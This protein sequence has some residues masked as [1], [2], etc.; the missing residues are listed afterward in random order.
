MIGWEAVQSGVDGSWRRFQR[1]AREDRVFLVPEGAA[2]QEGA[3]EYSVPLG[4]W[5]RHP[6]ERHTL[7]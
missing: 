7:L 1:V 6:V 3:T 2:W 5:E 4:Y